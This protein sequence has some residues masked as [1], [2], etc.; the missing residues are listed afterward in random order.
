M[1]QREEEKL[2][3]TNMYGGV[4]HLTQLKD[5]V[6]IV[7]AALGTLTVIKGLMEYSRDAAQRRFQ[8]LVNLRIRFT[9]TPALRAVR[10]AIESGRPAALRRVSRN[11]RVDFAAFFEEVALMLNSN[12]ISERVAHSMFGFYAIVAD[13]SKA[14]W[15]G[16]NREDNAI[17]W[18]PFR[19]FAAR[20]R[21]YA[22]HN[23]CPDMSEY[24]V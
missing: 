12:L 11:N 2:H 1:I 16:F 14:F 6:T 7:A 9:D 3:T 5:I 15:D 23:P 20:M 18:K 19:Y 17:Y 22:R 8:A 13:D 21:E 4:M 10:G 24:I